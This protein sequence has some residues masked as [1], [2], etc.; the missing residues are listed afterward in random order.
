M[1]VAVVEAGGAEALAVL[2]RDAR[3]P[4]RGAYLCRAE[5]ASGPAHACLTEAL[6]RRGI[7]R[8]LRRA[9]RVESKLVESIG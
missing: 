7:Q 5:G 6:A 9:V 3:L 4:G 1:R 2:D 8:S